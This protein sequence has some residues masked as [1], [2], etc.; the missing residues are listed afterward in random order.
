MANSEIFDLLYSEFR[1]K[2]EDDNRVFT[3]K[4]VVGKQQIRIHFLKEY[5]KIGVVQ[6]L[7]FLNKLQEKFA[8]I[9]DWTTFSFNC[10]VSGNNIISIFEW[11]WEW[12]PHVWT[13]LFPSNFLTKKCIFKKNMI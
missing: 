6:R 10:F 9:S 4:Y 13:L 1:H 5:N 8:Y 7:D 11:K 12:D 2:F 3:Q